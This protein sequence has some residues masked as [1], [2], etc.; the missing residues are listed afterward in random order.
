MTKKVKEKKD[1]K[2]AANIV[3]EPAKPAAT[4]PLTSTTAKA[5]ND[6]IY[7]PI[8]LAGGTGPS[9]VKNNAFPMQKSLPIPYSSPMAKNLPNYEFL[10]MLP[11]NK[12]MQ[13]SNFWMQ[14]LSKAP[15][16]GKT[17]PSLSALHPPQ[18]GEQKPGI[19]E[20]NK[21]EVEN[22]MLKSRI[23]MLPTGLTMQVSQHEHLHIHCEFCGH[24]T[25]RHGDHID[26]IHDGELHSASVSGTWRQNSIGA[27]F[28]H[29]LGVTAKNPDGCRPLVEYPWHAIGPPSGAKN[30]GNEERL[31]P[32]PEKMRQLWNKY[33]QKLKQDA[34][35][36]GYNSVRSRVYQ[37]S[38][39]PIL[40]PQINRL[41]KTTLLRESSRSS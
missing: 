41:A 16:D 18:P 23:K 22:R 38:S 24:P 36:S 33:A 9:E 34:E 4:C 1:I 28:V 10:C 5:F 8:P 21:A 29:K 19:V 7:T 13:S 35:M 27:V 15:M 37:I 40:P 20:E 2:I 32:D 17:L 11:L 14:Q 6:Y 25:I 30:G 39:S 3:I 26:Y 12:P 31:D